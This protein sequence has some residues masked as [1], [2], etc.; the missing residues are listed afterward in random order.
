MANEDKNKNADGKAATP[1]TA[2]ELTGKLTVPQGAVLVRYVGPPAAAIDGNVGG[3]VAGYVYTVSCEVAARVL[4]V[5]KPVFE[6]VYEDDRTA[7][8]AAAKQ[9]SK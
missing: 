1:A 4:L 7:V 2:K 8:E 3:V 5:K 9:A 6:L